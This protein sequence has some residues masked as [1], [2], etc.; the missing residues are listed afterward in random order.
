MRPP[1]ALLCD[2]YPSAR[3]SLLFCSRVCQI[4]KVRKRGEKEALKASQ[5]DKAQNEGEEVD[6]EEKL[7]EEM[8]ELQVGLSHL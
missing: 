6:E 8:E 3:S 2:N 1:V 4:L 5:K 7:M